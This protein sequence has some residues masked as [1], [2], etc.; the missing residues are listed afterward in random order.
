K[1]LAARRSPSRAEPEAPDL[2]L[3]D[4]DLRVDAAAPDDQRLVGAALREVQH[5]VQLGDASGR[6]TDCES[7]VRTPA[8]R[9]PDRE[10][11]RCRALPERHA[12]ALRGELLVREVPG[13]LRATAA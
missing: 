3:V 13:R 5:A 8:R 12:D 11:R 10:E 4:V 1:K 9:G 7:L 6:V 2:L